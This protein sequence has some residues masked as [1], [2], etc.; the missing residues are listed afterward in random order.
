[1]TSLS[2]LLF[3]LVIQYKYLL[4]FPV[5]VIEGPLIT[6]ASGFLVSKGILSPIIALLVLIAADL[7]SDLFC[8]A[9][10]R[11]GKDWKITAWIFKKFGFDAHKEK[12][13][14][15]FKEHGGKVILTGKITH[16]L[17]IPFML[18][19]G[20]FEMN[21]FKFI[22]YNTIGTAI[23]SSVF[24]YIGYL[25]GAAYAKYASQIGLVSTLLL[26]SAILVVVVVAMVKKNKK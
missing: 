9:I 12:V 10:G 16:A 21:I 13:K 11:F 25:A 4:L 8:Y 26:I 7:V 14:R 19:A 22:L 23:K 18:G 24:M 3:Q 20:Y 6:F 2:T 15:S 5:A 1:M 17:S